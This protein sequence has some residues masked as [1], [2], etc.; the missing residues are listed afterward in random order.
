MLRSWTEL[1]P[2]ALSDASPLPLTLRQRE[3]LRWAMAGKSNE[4]IGQ[5]IGRSAE[6]VKNHLRAVYRRLGVHS[7]IEAALK[8]AR[9]AP[10]YIRANDT[11]IVPWESRLEP[12][13]LHPARHHPISR[14]PARR[15][16]LP[17]HTRPSPP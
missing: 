6:T 3:I 13:P 4:L 15:S 9:T 16:R 14:P 17:R 11:E 10:S 8:V 7:R 2:E 1:R 12:P 5:I